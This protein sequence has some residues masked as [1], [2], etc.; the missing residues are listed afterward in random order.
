MNE[1]KIYVK[2]LNDMLNLYLISIKLSCLSLILL[3]I[4][5][6]VNKN[7][8]KIKDNKNKF[9]LFISLLVISII[10][11]I[12]IIFTISSVYISILMNNENFIKLMNE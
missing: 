10:P 6:F 12:N 9:I 2:G 4:R 1:N 5:L 11:I 3:L 8:L 7:N